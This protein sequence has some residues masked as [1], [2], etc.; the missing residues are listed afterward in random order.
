MS[1]NIGRFEL[2]S[3]LAR[4]PAT[5]VYKVLDPE[6]GQTVA[7]KV[8]A[9]EPL[10][11]Q[12]TT[13]VQNLLQEAA[14]SKVLNSPNIASLH[15]TEEV[16]GKFLASMEYVQGNSIATMLARREGFSIW[17]L[18]DIARQTCQ[19]LDHAHKH[20]VVHYTLEPAKIMVAWD[21]TVKVLGFGIS[22]MS[23][24]AAQASGA[25]PEV[26]HYMSPEQ[27]QGDLLDPRSNIFSLGAIL[28]EM[29]T[30]RKAFQGND[31]AE[32]R[33]QIVEG[34]PVSPDRVNHKIHPALSQVILKALAKSPDERYQSGQELVNE[35]ERCKES[36]AKAAPAKA[37]PTKAAAAQSARVLTGQGAA[38]PATPV[39]KTPPPKSP[40]AAARGPLASKPAVAAKT[41]S[42]VATAKP[43]SAKPPSAGRS[44]AAANAA[45]S[46]SAPPHVASPAPNARKAAAGIG[47]TLPSSGLAS[48][49]VAPVEPSEKFIS[50]CV[51]ASVDAMIEQGAQLSSA[52]EI[53]SEVEA[54][55]IT[56]DPMMAED[57]KPAVSRLSFSDLEELPPLKEAYVAP[58]PP[59]PESETIP[60]AEAVFSQ[61]SAVPEKPKIQPR[62]V[63]K[64]A[65]TQIKKT[66][67]KLFVYSIAGALGVILVIV[68][69]IA[70]RIHSES[71]DEEGEAGPPSTSSSPAPEQPAAQRQIPS[72]PA[73][74]PAAVQAD[75]SEPPSSPQPEVSVK[76]KYKAKPPKAP[77][78]PALV[79]G[80]LTVNSTPGGADV[81]VDGHN[82]P[83]W[84]TPYDLTGLAPGPH[85]VSIS[86]AGYASET[87]TV[88]VGSGSKSFLVVQL[89]QLS[90]TV[91]ITSEP[92]GAEV[93][94]DGKDTGRLT[95]VQ[96]SVDR[97]GN[98]TVVVK[99]QGYLEET[100]TA[101]LQLGQAFHFTPSLRALGNTDEIKFKRLF[102][103]GDV[104]GM[105]T[106]N[107]KTQPKGAQIAVNRRIIEKNSPAEFYLN[108]GTYTVDITLSGFK[109][110]HR[111][112]NV[113]KGGKVAMDEN[114]DRE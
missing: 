1:K 45:P 103:R 14:S 5:S 10:G 89:A 80:Q 41:G 91:S 77:R 23:A 95:P 63:A 35:L 15:G 87:R 114:L 16:N 72:T 54:R 44:V 62:E 111:V 55:K 61:N 37:A 4:S 76:P 67:P 78:A 98:H 59:S 32:V 46:K 27:L 22:T 101:N 48:T 81:S 107:I 66:P 75:A 90:A 39:A 105:G 20:R 74:P 73:Q 92:A 51:K 71:S 47:G 57:V 26:L 113:E 52:A 58:R 108:P 53:A 11:E 100:I 19:G 30:E 106:V 64:N 70:F 21:G 33:Q 85:T 69:A 36:T 102:G 2:Q 3:E 7:L 9:L 31:G 93:F 17:D 38:R 99:K 25:P 29:V 56:V 42:A 34:N 8:L 109:S 6:S 84:V 24:F 13:L 40:S 68:T 28:Y 96:V 79:P 104:T 65:V 97:P 112:I 49:T 60:E 110:I 18:L 82:D 83:N 88:D 86:K 43:A 94:L 50:T 12:A